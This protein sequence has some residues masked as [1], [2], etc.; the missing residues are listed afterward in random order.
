[1]VRAKSFV[2]RET[3]GAKGP[4]YS[5]LAP[6]MLGRVT[7]TAFVLLVVLAGCRT[8]SAAPAAY[9]TAQD[10]FAGANCSLVK[11]PVEPELMAWDPGLRAQLDKLRR[12]HV[13]AVR[14][15]AK[16]CEVSLELLPDC[17][18]PKNKYVYSPL[19]SADSRVA[20][21]VDELLAQLPLGAS[22]VSSSLRADASLRADFKLVGAAALPAGSTVTE[23]DLV[24]PSCKAA[25]HVVSAVYLGGFGVAEERGEAT[26]NAFSGGVDAIVREG[27]PAIC[28]RAAA[29]GVPL[30]GCSAPIRVALTPLTGAAPPPTCPE[31]STFDGKKC[32]KDAAA[33]PICSTWGGAEP[34][35]GCGSDAPAA[36]PSQVFDQANVERVVRVKSMNAKR[37]CWETAPSS[38]RSISVNVTTSI[39]PQGK[40]TAADPQLVSAEGPT[41]VATTVA[42]CLA[43]DVL[44]WEFPPPGASTSVVLPFHL[45]RQ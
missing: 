25:T 44:T 45:L 18:G 2:S 40:V 7:R 6:V 42:R 36:D 15:E 3:G 4:K 5:R 24:G 8:K 33:A 20:H 38:V 31:S 34:E 28:D 13:V 10:P 17:I 30:D 41:D 21:S 22:N 1:M 39:D 35:A 23:Y 11:P 12:Q 26:T 29:E 37:S 27:H 32:V 9:P 16:G 43:N 19:G 14:Y